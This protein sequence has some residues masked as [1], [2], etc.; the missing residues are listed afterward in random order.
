[1]PLPLFTYSDICKQHKAEFNVFIRSLTI[2][3]LEFV[4]DLI[5]FLLVIKGNM[6]LHLCLHVHLDVILKEVKYSASHVQVN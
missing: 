6:G 4:S 1:M 3:L 2:P 5:D